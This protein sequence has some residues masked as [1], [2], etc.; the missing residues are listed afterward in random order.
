MAALAIIVFIFKYDD[1]LWPLVVA[2]RAEMYPITAGLV[3]YAGQFFGQKSPLLDS[4]SFGN[5]AH[6]CDLLDSATLHDQG[7]RH[8]RPEGL[9]SA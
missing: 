6:L 7:N 8:A 2:Q 1:L 9:E 5:L 4:F 3:E